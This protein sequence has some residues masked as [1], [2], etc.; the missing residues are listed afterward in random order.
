MMDV[1]R[2][3]RLQNDSDAGTD[4]IGDEMMVK[5][6]RGQKGGDRRMVF[7]HAAIA[8]KKDVGFI[9]DRLVRIAEHP[10]QRFLHRRN[11]LVDPIENRDRDRFEPVV[12]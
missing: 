11:P 5:T 3:A 7:I 2:F 6:G 1:A 10:F 12:V 4:F 9:F 8:E